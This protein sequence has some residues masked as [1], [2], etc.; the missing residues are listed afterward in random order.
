MENYCIFAVSQS[1]LWSCVLHESSVCL[2]RVFWKQYQDEGYLDIFWRGF[3]LE[4]VAISLARRFRRCFHHEETWQLVIGPHFRR[5]KQSITVEQSGWIQHRQN[6]GNRLRPHARRSIIPKRYPHRHPNI[7]NRRWMWI[8]WDLPRPSTHHWTI[9]ISIIPW[10]LHNE[11][12]KFFLPI[13][14]INKVKYPEKRLN[15]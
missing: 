1:C 12:I 2:R 3:Q 13:P 9:E 4:K 6:N 7:P 5:Q 15:G 11:I 10:I 14:T 8:N